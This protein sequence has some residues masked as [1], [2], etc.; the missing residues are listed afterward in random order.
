MLGS[1][2]GDQ[3]VWSQLKPPIQEYTCAITIVLAAM[4]YLIAVCSVPA[5]PTGDHCDPS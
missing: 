2:T 5:G 1:P 3:S 4:I